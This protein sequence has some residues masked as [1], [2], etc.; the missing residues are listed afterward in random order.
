[1]IKSIFTLIVVM[2]LFLSCKSNL[3]SKE[4]Y[5]PIGLFIE[6]ELA[7]IDSFHLTIKRYDLYNMDSVSS[8]M[9]KTSFRELVNELLLNNLSA[10]NALDK[11]KE[12]TINDLKLDFITLSYVN[13]EK[14]INKIELHI[15]P[16]SE[17]VKSLYAEKI[18]KKNDSIITKKILLTSGS[19]L[20]VNTIININNKVEKRTERYNFSLNYLK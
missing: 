20:L 7:L 10:P 3:K 11:Y 5:Y 8:I 15:D 2:S 16:L 13:T 1:M 18:E 14:D 19:Q 17:K 4:Q 12:T 6:Q 9:K